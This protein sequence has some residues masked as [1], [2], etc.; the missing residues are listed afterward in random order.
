M[1]HKFARLKLTGPMYAPK[2]SLGPPYY[3][4]CW[5]LGKAVIGEKNVD[6]LVGVC[7]HSKKAF[8]IKTELDYPIVV[9]PVVIKNL[10]VQNEKCEEAE[11][12]MNLACSLN[13]TTFELWA[14]RVEATE[15]R[16]RNW[17]RN[18]QALASLKLER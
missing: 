1:R 3:S 4:V 18:C 5:I 6:V 14:P 7:G 16:V 12:C 9:Y 10:V 13:K 11:R 17:K 8:T 15:E 2:E